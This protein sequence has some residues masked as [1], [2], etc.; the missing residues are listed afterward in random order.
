MPQRV[1]VSSFARLMSQGMAS[2]QLRKRLPP[3][4]AFHLRHAQQQAVAVCRERAAAHRLE[5][6][7]QPCASC[8]PG[9]C[10]NA[11]QV[12][13]KCLGCDTTESV[14]SAAASKLD[15]HSVQ[16]GCQLLCP[17]R[18]TGVT[19]GAAACVTSCKQ[20]PAVPSWP[21][22]HLRGYINLCW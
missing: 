20:G 3:C 2:A 19:G 16:C 15:A 22:I 5:V 21:D 8:F 4:H 9:G 10:C 14:C 18:T 1:Q 7:S 11:L 13:V 6:M 12:A 17:E